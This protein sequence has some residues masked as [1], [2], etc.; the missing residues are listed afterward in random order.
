MR[1][2]QRWIWVRE[3]SLELLQG[4]KK[5]FTGLRQTEENGNVRDG[6]GERGAVPWGDSGGWRKN[7]EGLEGK[8]ERMEG[9]EEDPKGAGGCGMGRMEIW[10]RKP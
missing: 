6:S 3:G 5:G 1:R 4:E 2:N 9:L 7:P 10:S 8:S